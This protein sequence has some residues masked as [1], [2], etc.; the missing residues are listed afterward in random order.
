MDEFFPNTCRKA[1]RES[2]SNFRMEVDRQD[3]RR[4]LKRNSRQN[5]NTLYPVK[6]FESQAYL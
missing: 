5:R 6:G 1:V 4:A 2:E 3:S